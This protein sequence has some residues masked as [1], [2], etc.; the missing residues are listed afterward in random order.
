M[1]NITQTNN[2]K[3]TAI[4]PHNLIDSNLDFSYLLKQY[5]RNVYDVES[6]YK[7][8]DY[9]DLLNQISLKV[10]EEISKIEKE[11]QKKRAIVKIGSTI[12]EYIIT[13]VEAL[14]NLNNLSVKYLYTISDTNLNFTISSDKLNEGFQVEFV[15]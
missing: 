9:T 2:S 6:K 1:S 4:N 8:I 7:E 15:D 5:L 10:T 3:S 14:I 12:K 11:K 13:N